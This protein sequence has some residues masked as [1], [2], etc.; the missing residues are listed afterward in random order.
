RELA[1]FAQFSSDLDA[2]TKQ[3]IERGQR[4]TEL[5]K[6]KQYHPY[7]IAEQV[8]SIM[9]ATEGAF[10]EVPTE[11]IKPVQADLLSLLEDKHGAIMKTLNKGDKPTDDAKKTI[12]EAAK[13][14]A[15]SY[16]VTV[17]PKETESK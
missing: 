8:A 14:V 6:Q 4:L 7:S 2:D 10:D 15:K 3:R 11:K 12:L 16:A 17:K 1:S 5:L 9:A 13:K